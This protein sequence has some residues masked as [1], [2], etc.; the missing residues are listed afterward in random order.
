L[1]SI[2]GRNFREAWENKVV[3]K[4]GYELAYFISPDDLIKNKKSGRIRDFFS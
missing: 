4:F 1:T 3:G 2:S